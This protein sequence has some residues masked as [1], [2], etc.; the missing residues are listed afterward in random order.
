ML[1]SHIME[2][3]RNP[4]QNH[5]MS[6]NQVI[7]DKLSATTDTIAGVKN[8]FVSFTEI[9]KLGINPRSHYTT[10][11]A[12]YAYPATYIRKAIGDTMPAAGSKIPYAA[13]APYVNIFKMSGNVVNLVNMRA[14]DLVKYESAL[15]DILGDAVV[16]DAKTHQLNDTTDSDDGYYTGNIPGA[17]LWRLMMAIRAGGASRYKTTSGITALF[18]KI[19]IDAV[20]DPGKGIIHPNEKVQLAVFNTRKIVN[21]YRQ[22]NKHS[23]AAI[24]KSIA[25]GRAQRSVVGS[26]P[27]WTTAR[28]LKEPDLY[29]TWI[30]RGNTFPSLSAAVLSVHPHT[31]DTL[32]G[33]VDDITIVKVLNAYS[34][35][36]NESI[37]YRSAANAMIATPMW[38]IERPRVFT[39]L[40]L[41]NLAVLVKIYQQHPDWI[42]QLIK[43]PSDVKHTKTNNMHVFIQEV[44]HKKVSIIPPLETFIGW[45]KVLAH[46]NWLTP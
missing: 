1:L 42:T 35:Q 4:T 21:N 25:L 28:A 10:P 34:S 9:E 14:T 31:I 29:A 46:Y 16:D 41:P 17:V 8:L 37:L 19:G 12:V 33:E 44:T 39:N 18:I 23:P 38:L 22:E 3:R 6:I 5:K 13:E 36:Y 2:H 27:D 20:Y 43:S 40:E 7:K 26:H 30:S 24:E 32:Q 11:N 45:Y 15:R